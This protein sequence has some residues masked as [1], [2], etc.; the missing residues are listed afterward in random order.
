MWHTQRQKAGLPLSASL[1][2]SMCWAFLPVW[3]CWLSLAFLSRWTRHSSLCLCQQVA[4]SSRVCFSFLFTK[5]PVTL[6]GNPSPL[7]YH[8]RLI[9]SAKSYFQIRSCLH[10]LVM[11]SLTCLLEKHH[12]SQHLKWLKAVATGAIELR[13]FQPSSP[14]RSGYEISGGSS[15]QHPSASQSPSNSKERWFPLMCWVMAQSTLTRPQV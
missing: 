12:S 2:D 7:C 10:V 9:I 5:T 11:R 4:C 1:G 3:C 13:P 8:F 14:Q 15:S 6:G